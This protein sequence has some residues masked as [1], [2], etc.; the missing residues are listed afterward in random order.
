MKTRLGLT[1]AACLCRAIL[2]SPPGGTPAPELFT[3]DPGTPQGLQEMFQPTAEP[4][5]LLSAHRGGAGPDFPENCLA[6]FEHTLRHAW[7]MLEIDLRYTKDGHLVLH[8]DPTLNR[9]TN[10]TGRVAD[11]TLQELQ[12]LRLKDRNGNLTAHRIPTL[13]ETMIWARG[14]TILILDKKEV[15]V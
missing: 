1:F 6:T 2:A 10:G 14:K 4:L 8:H 9:T 5:P 13:D 12:Q 3:I 7:S 11:H 15:P